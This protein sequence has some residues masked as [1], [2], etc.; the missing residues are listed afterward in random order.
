MKPPRT[1][2]TAPQE[3]DILAR[4]RAGEAVASIAAD[5]LVDPSY[6]GL[7]AKRRGVKLRQSAEARRN[8]SEAVMGNSNARKDR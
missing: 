6:P 3:H 5:Y 2:L 8:H 7:L 4:Y 1:K